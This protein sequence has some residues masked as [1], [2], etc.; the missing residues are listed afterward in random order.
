MTLSD[1]VRGRSFRF[2]DDPDCS[3]SLSLRDPTCSLF[4]AALLLVLAV[5]EAVAA[6]LLALA[7]VE[8]VAALLLPPAAVEV[9]AVDLVAFLRGRPTFRPVFLDFPSDPLLLESFALEERG[10]LVAVSAPRTLAIMIS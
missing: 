5:A 7:A 6:L 2:L 10:S 4:V 9:V 3:G 1:L 8:V